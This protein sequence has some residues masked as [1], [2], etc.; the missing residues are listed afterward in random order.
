MSLEQAHFGF[1]ERVE[2]YAYGFVVKLFMQITIRRPKVTF[3]GNGITS[4]IVCVS[5][6]EA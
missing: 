3:D 6:Q 1:Y 2:S 5:V 4:C